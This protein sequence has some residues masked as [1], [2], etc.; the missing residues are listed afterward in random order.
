MQRQPTAV[1]FPRILASA[2]LHSLLAVQLF[3][4]A[5]VYEG[6]ELELTFDE[7]KTSSRRNPLDLFKLKNAQETR[8]TNPALP[9]NATGSTTR[10]T[11]IPQ[12]P[13]TKPPQ[14]TTAVD[15]QEPSAERDSGE[16]DK[17]EAN[18]VENS[19]D[20]SEDSDG[21]SEIS[22]EVNTKDPRRDALTPLQS[23]ELSV[24]IQPVNVSLDGIGTGILPDGADRTGE[25]QLSNLPT[26]YERGATYKVVNWQPSLICHYPLYFEDAMLERHGHVRF[27]RL[28]SLASGAKF[29][30]TLPLLPYLY[31]LKPKHECLYALGHYRVGSC[32]PLVR[33]NL[34][35]DRNAAVVEALALSS[36]FWAA[37][38]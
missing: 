34:P 15:N 18:E 37:P 4:Q 8:S 10:L 7:V 1:T 29:F 3:S 13:A 6:A 31:T 16:Q 38:L 26:G 14:I 27:G 33:D 32:A 24:L 36:F 25:A 28:Q 5:P 21:D 11:S 30:G 9:A 20:E 22:D 2:A 23:R 12:P 17:D 35:W 19:Q